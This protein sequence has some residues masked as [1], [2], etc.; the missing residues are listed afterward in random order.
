ME[1]I[2]HAH[3]FEPDKSFFKS[4]RKNKASC[5]III[6]NNSENCG[7]Y[8]RNECSWLAPFGWQKCPYG[9]YKE[10]EGFTKKANAYNKWIK[11]RKDKYV[12][13]L[14][15]LHSHKDILTEVGDYVF[16]PYS[17]ITMNE[18]ISF[19]SKGGLFTKEN[20]FLHKSDFT[21]NNIISICDFRPQAMMGG[22]IT[23]Y[24][25]EQVPK[26]IKHLSEVIPEKYNELCITYERAK[27][28]VN[29]FN[30]IGRKALL[31]TIIPNRGELIDC[32]KAKWIW[33]GEYLTSYNS[34][35]SFMIISNFSELRL[36]PLDDCVI[37]ITSNDQ[38][39]KNT[40]FVS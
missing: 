39:N 30:Y 29:N 7:L 4:N 11:E 38:V 18:S 3:I 5:S 12:D 40:K 21:I 25:L 1:K 9:K 37:E 17:H 6:C 14:D 10:E 22:E 33:D 24:Q 8:K 32:H 34:S 31:N 20:V 23:S 13:V 26:F 36:K 27:T 2:V 16:L 35:A 15:K 28:I 19:L